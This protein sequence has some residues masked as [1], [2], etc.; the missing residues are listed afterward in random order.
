ML[1]FERISKMS[2]FVGTF[3][4]WA[5]MNLGHHMKTGTKVLCGPGFPAYL[6]GTKK[7]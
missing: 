1:K 7:G 3:P 4:D 5:L 6:P 2:H